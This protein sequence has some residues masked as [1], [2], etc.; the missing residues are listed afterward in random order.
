MRHLRLPALAAVVLALTACAD[1]V[2]PRESADAETTAPRAPG[3]AAPTGNTAAATSPQPEIGGPVASTS[4]SA[5]DEARATTDVSAGGD[6]PAA[7]ERTEA[8]LAALVSAD[9]EFCRLLV[10]LDGSAPMA[11]SPDELALCEQEVILQLEAQVSEQDAAVFEAIEI[12]GATVEADTA[13]VTAQNVGG[14]FAEGFSDADIVLQR[15]AGEWYVDLQ[16]S[17][18]GTAP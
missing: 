12:D 10:G 14:V 4:T 1:A 11:D 13:R 8:F 3:E 6:G 5:P 15:F 2:G 16:R 9:P 7:A 17:D 18:L